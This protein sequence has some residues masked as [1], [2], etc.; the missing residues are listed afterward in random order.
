MPVVR[1]RGYLG[2][3]VISTAASGPRLVAVLSMT[4]REPMPDSSPDLTD[5]L[6]TALF[7]PMSEIADQVCGGMLLSGAVVLLESRNGLSRM[8]SMV[9]SPRSLKLARV[10]VF[11]RVTAVT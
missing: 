1:C 11:C 10:S 5:K 4:F 6:E 8:G 3:I 2:W 9:A 7:R